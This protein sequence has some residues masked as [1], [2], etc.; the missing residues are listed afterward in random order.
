MPTLNLITHCGADKV[1]RQQ[2]V[3]AVTPSPTETWFPLPHNRLIE[4]VELSLANC[5]LEVV[6]QAHALYHDDH[7]YFGLL[8]VARKN[9]DRVVKADITEGFSVTRSTGDDYSW[10]LGLRNSHDK[11]FPAAMLLGSQVFVCDNL[12]FSSSEIKISRKHTRFCERDLVQSVS[13]G[14]G[15]LTAMWHSNDVR[16]AAYKN[17]ELSNRDVHD[18]VVKSLDSGAI[19]VTQIPEVLKE[20]RT[21][22]HPEFSEHHNVWR[23]FNAVTEIAK[24][25]SLFVL[26]KRTGALHGLLDGHCGLVLSN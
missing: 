5:N 23:F 4:Q 9:D 12:A 19:T 26:P 20:Y 11:T 25:N 18:L 24:Q 8:Q 2:V 14:V 7:R 13:D 16:Y 17:V 22:R 3:D 21:P 1:E 10:V 6:N 15:R